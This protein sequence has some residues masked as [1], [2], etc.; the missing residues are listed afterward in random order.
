MRISEKINS[1]VAQAQ[2][3]GREPKRVLVGLHV[4]A[5]LTLEYDED[6]ITSLGELPI[7][8]SYK[9]AANEVSISCMSSDEYDN[10]QTPCPECGFM[11]YSNE[12]CGNC[13]IFRE[14]DMADEARDLVDLISYQGEALGY[15]FS[16]I[17]VEEQ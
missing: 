2:S 4:Y 14:F 3:D 11:C 16:L 9:L 17:E 5:M 12:Y 10:L 13:G 7:E 1:L 15:G 8:L 6:E